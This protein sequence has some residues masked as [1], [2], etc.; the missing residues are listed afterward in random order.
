[1][2]QLV[3][4]DVGGAAAVAD[5]QVAARAQVDD[6]VRERPAGRPAAGARPAHPAVRDDAVVEDE[7]LLVGSREHVR[8]RRELCGDALEPIEVREV[9]RGRV[10]KAHEAEVEV[11]EAALAAGE[12]EQVEARRARRVLAA[13]PRVDRGDVGR[14]RRGELREPV[15]AV[16]G[17]GVDHVD[18]LAAHA[19][20]H[21]V[22]LREVVPAPAHRRD[23]RGGR[24]H[25]EE[26]SDRDGRAEEDAHLHR[27]T[28]VRD[29]DTV[30]DEVDRLYKLPLEEF[31][32]A[33]NELAKRLGDTSVK[34]LKKP[35]VPAWTVNQLARTREVDVRR[36]LR[37]GEQLE[38]AQKQAVEGGDQQA[39]ERARDGRARRAAPPALAGRGPAPSRRAPRE[40][41]D[42]RARRRARFAPAPRRRRGER[43]CARDA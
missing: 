33:R 1:M 10:R 4:S 15:R 11:S 40:R 31:T 23:R 30:A 43:C 8:R 17:Q 18:L 29:N 7:V 25:E 5:R 21:A 2:Q 35:T 37:A 20:V 26:R 19:V 41:L 6:P 12:V 22:R 32:A 9:H 14:D 13:P 3:S 34:Q 28:Q 27:V 42:A 24:R 36:L 38:Q 39:F 16:G